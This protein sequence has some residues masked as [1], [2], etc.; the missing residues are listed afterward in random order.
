M[1]RKMVVTIFFSIIM[2]SILASS[3][4]LGEASEQNNSTSWPTFHSDIN[5]SGYSTSIAPVTN[6]TLWAYNTQF[7]GWAGSGPAPI[8][9]SPAVANGIVYFGSDD[10][11]VYAINA[12]T[13]AKIWNF[14]TDYL[15]VRSSP[16]VADGVVYIGADDWNLYALN[17]STGVKI[18]S[19]KT[20]NCQFSSPTVNEGILYANA[21]T[22]N[23]GVGVN[24]YGVLALNASNG[25]KLWNFT[26]IGQIPS[27][28][29]PAISNGVLYVGFADGNIYALNASIGSQIWNFTTGQQVESSPSVANGIVYVGSDDNNIYALNA[30][31]GTK[32]WNYTT[33]AP[34]ETSPAILDD[35]VYAGSAYGTLYSLNAVTGEPIWTYSRSGILLSSPAI[36]GGLVFEGLFGITPGNFYAL[37][38]STGQLVWSYSTGGMH[39]S[40]AIASGVVYVGS[41]NGNLYAF[42]PNPNMLNLQPTT[43]SI[44]CSSGPAG[45]LPCV[46][47]TASVSGSNPTGTITW[48]TSTSTGTFSSKQT[49]LTSGVSSTTYTDNPQALVTI[50]AS[51]SGDVINAQSSTNTVTIMSLWNSMITPTPTPTASQTSTPSE[52]TV[53]NPTTTPPIAIPQTPEFPNAILLTI[54]IGLASM[55]FLTLL[56]K[57]QGKTL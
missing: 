29:S 21:W 48:T 37:N 22:K 36:A 16:S 42:A 6:Q 47:L 10:G 52:G 17:A 1:K 35:K 4:L 31:T 20:A 45:S 15:Y 18:W 23:L 38:C 41:E 50:S 3:P 26:T 12:N 51:Y 39:S 28:S 8:E 43:L 11:N 53:T 14:T 27:S 19:Y 33:N 49:S 9:S 30:S 25:N 46:K 13:G 56:V 40:P 54:L 24:A 2:F 57:K 7:S 34:V 32:L 55:A 5:R 44:S